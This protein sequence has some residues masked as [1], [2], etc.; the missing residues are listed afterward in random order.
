MEIA[1]ALFS[2]SLNTNIQG[3]KAAILNFDN[4]GFDV[5]LRMIL[6]RLKC[7]GTLTV[8]KTQTSRN[9]RPIGELSFRIMVLDSLK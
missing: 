5:T 9:R 8:C 3:L 4:E 6:L 2:S 7:R 1:K